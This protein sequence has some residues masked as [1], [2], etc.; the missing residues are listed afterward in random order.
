MKLSLKH[1]NYKLKLHIARL[2]MKAEMQNKH[3][4]KKKLKK[5]ITRI[6]IQLKH[7]LGLYNNV[8]YQ[9]NKAVNSRLKVILLSHN[10]KLIRLR[11]QQN[12]PR[13]D[14]QK[15]CT[16]KLYITIQSYTLSDEQYEGLSFG[17]DTHIPVKVNKNA[18]YTKFEVFLSKFI[19]GHFQHSRKQIKT[20]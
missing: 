17:L 4:E 20:N 7:S 9:I 2:V 13:K 14:E 5:K 12:K 11:E 1:N 3:F 8:I 6:G 10:N 18:I 19:E 16:D 15:K